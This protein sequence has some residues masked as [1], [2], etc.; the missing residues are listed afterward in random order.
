MP[1]LDS[2]DGSAGPSG[3]GAVDSS[4]PGFWNGRNIGWISA[5]VGVVGLGV[6]SIFGLKAF[7][8]WD[9]R[10]KECKPT[11]T[12][13]AKAAGSRASDAATISTIGF[14]VGA[15]ALAVGTILILTSGGGDKHA[16][17]TTTLE[18]SVLPSPGGAVIS[19][20]HPW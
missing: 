1:L 7:S 19:M 20:R 11:C 3:G 15:G 9:D 13:A 16:A 4:A 2:S 5:G 17:R 18:A 8:N 6:G 14:A 10:Q 12:E